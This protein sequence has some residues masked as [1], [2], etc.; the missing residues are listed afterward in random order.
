MTRRPAPSFSV[1][2]LSCRLVSRA[3]DMR[4]HP[5]PSEAILW[6]HLRRR[7]VLGTR[8]RR[9]HPIGFYIADFACLAHK[10]IVEVD[11]AGH[12]EERDELRDAFLARAGFRVLRVKAWM[13]E[14]QISVVLEVI[15]A[16]L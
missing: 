10:L 8:W 15:R 12:S 5:T 7:A 9:Q 2:P 14:R 11:G 6:E 1:P 16:A 3:R 13:V 4:Q